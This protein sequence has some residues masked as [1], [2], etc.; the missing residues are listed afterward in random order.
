MAAKFLKACVNVCVGYLFL[1]GMSGKN[2]FEIKI[3]FWL[4]LRQQRRK[5][6]PAVCIPLH[7][8]WVCPPSV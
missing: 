5:N 1:I 8:E 3:S 6:C 4:V 7:V 2:S